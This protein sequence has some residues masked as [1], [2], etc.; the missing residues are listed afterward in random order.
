MTIVV[1]AGLVLR[2]LLLNAC[3]WREW[4]DISRWSMT[5][6]DREITLV[7]HY[8][9]V[10]KTTED[11]AGTDR[12]TYVTYTPYSCLRSSTRRLWWS[13]GE[14]LIWVQTIYKSA[15]D[16]VWL[17]AA[18]ICSWPL[19]KQ[20]CKDA[21]RKLCCARRKPLHQKMTLLII[22]PPLRI[23][24]RDH[25]QKGSCRTLISRCFKQKR[26]KCN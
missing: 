4:G 14:L 17:I 16:G 13:T 26:H 12:Q 19:S 22:N 6:T 24:D 25:C 10:W 20:T 8:R 15:Y 9:A 23:Y 5:L 2:T 3:Y 11:L 1:S 21:L 18:I 7:R